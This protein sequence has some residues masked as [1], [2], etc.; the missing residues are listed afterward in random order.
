MSA[1][2]VQAHEA[3]R[4]NRWLPWIGWLFS[5][6]A[7]SILLMSARWK[8]TFD[9]WY[10]AEW[11][12]IG[13]DPSALPRIGLIQ[14]ACVVLYVTPPTAVLGAVLLTVTLAVPMANQGLFLVMLS[15][16]ALFLPFGAPNVVASVYDV[17]LPEVRSTALS[18]QYF[19]ESIGAASA[20]VI[21]G[22]IADRSSLHDAILII[23]VSTWLV[24]AV[25]FAVAAFLLPRDIARLRAQM[26]ERA[27][28]EQ[29]G[30]AVISVRTG[31]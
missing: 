5:A 22:L 27:R 16:T 2:A 6:G 19:V 12:R 10:V 15:L 25:L 18:I 7:L 24:C 8:L 20:P 28:E 29:G 3:P 30:Q 31:D 23:C 9:P 17:T 14:L 21:A 1:V 13:W 26:R 11:S 4:L